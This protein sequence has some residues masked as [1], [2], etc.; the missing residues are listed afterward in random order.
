VAVGHEI[1]LVGELGLRKTVGA[2]WLDQNRVVT[3]AVTGEEGCALKQILDIAGQE[4]PECT[5]R[6]LF[7]PDDLAETEML[8][9]VLEA[10]R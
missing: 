9:A 5:L 4:A 1:R 8:R 2:R 3:L 6:L 7:H 10:A